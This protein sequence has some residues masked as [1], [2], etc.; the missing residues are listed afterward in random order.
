M[1]IRP[2][3]PCRAALALVVALAVA[4]CGSHTQVRNAWAAP[5]VAVAASVAAAPPPDAVPAPDACA[6]DRPGRCV[7]DAGELPRCRPVPPWWHRPRP[8]GPG[9]GTRVST[10][11]TTLPPEP[12]TAINVCSPIVNVGA[13]AGPGAAASGAAA[14]SSAAAPG[15]GAA[16]EMEFKIKDLVEA[17][18]KTGETWVIVVLLVLLAVALVIHTW[19]RVREIEKGNGDKDRRWPWSTLIVGLAIVAVVGI[20]AWRSSAVAPA[21]PTSFAIGELVDRHIE[22]AL[23]ARAGRVASAPQEGETARQ[24]ADLRAELARLDARMAAA[25]AGALACCSSARAMEHGPG[26]SGPLL[27][28]VGLLLL[29]GAAGV[30]GARGWRTPAEPGREDTRGPG[31]PIDAAYDVED[32]LVPLR[33]SVAQRLGA[34]GREG[35]REASPRI[36][37]DDFLRACRALRRGLEAAG[38]APAPRKVARV[39]RLLAQGLPEQALK[40]IADALSGL[41]D[42]LFGDR[43]DPPDP[44]WRGRTASALGHVRRL[45]LAGSEIAGDEGA[46]ADSQAG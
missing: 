30:A 22:L 42:L 32:L 6:R 11:T 34:I 20:A 31:S 33:R 19:L 40:E 18:L 9:Q 24:L 17:R 23:A 38:D 27:A 35:A 2:L 12:A 7:A 45:L 37:I 3:F 44:W 29:G 15:D 8:E 4:S 1:R 14:A 21:A 43:R 13:A 25:A 28:G 16:T 41:A 39:P 36:R 26:W 46:E 10:S 5:P